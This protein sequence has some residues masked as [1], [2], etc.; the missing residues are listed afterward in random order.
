MFAAALRDAANMEASAAGVTCSDII[1]LAEVVLQANDL[2]MGMDPAALQF[3]GHAGAA[4]FA[5][6]CLASSVAALA[7]PFSAF[8]FSTF[9]LAL[10]AAFPLLVWTMEL[11]LFAIKV[12]AIVFPAVTCREREKQMGDTGVGLQPLEGN[13]SGLHNCS[14]YDWGDAIPACI[15]HKVEEHLIGG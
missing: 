7:F 2:A 5:P 12:I 6:G 3:G 9:A 14:S 15:T 4:G 13:I 11:L 10:V 8:A 1:A